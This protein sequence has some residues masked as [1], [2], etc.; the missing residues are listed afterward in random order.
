MDAVN[1]D[2]VVDPTSDATGDLVLGAVAPP[3]PFGMPPWTPTTRMVGA[4]ASTNSFP[5]PPPSLT[6]AGPDSALDTALV[7][8]RAEYVAGQARLRE[9][10]L[11]SERDAAD[12]LAKQIVEAE[13]L[14]TSPAS[15]DGEAI[16]SGLAGTGAVAGH[17]SSTTTVLWHD[18][19]DAL[20]AQLHYQTGHSVQNIWLLVPVVLEPE[21]PSYA[22]WRDLVLL[23]LRR[24]ALD[25]HILLDAMGT[26]PTALW[27]RLN[28]IVLSS[29]LG[30]SHWTS[31]T[32]SATLRT[33]TGP[34]WRSR[35]SFWAT[36]RPGLYVSMQAFGRSSRVTSPLASSAAR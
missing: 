24:Y 29:I 6:A 28:N 21:S 17:P 8:A 7:A 33:L 5:A 13:Q 14:L 2:A 35:A 26:V 25:D 34:G 30:R 22:W 10:A 15:H 1:T 11:A 16:S 36:S 9:A 32:S 20:V 12:A 31:M 3:F 18:P 4:G 27:L 19:A 23:T